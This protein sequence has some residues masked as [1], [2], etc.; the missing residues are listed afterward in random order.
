MSTS[1]EERERKMKE[2]RDKFESLQ[3]L[4]DPDASEELIHKH[5]GGGGVKTNTENDG[6]I[7]SSNKDFQMSSTSAKKGSKWNLLKKVVVSESAVSTS[8]SSVVS[9][10]HSWKNLQKNL[11]L[12]R[13]SRNSEFLG[14]ETSET[15]SALLKTPTMKA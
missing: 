2:M 1:T 14:R 3:L 4:V 12:E 5:L 15:V 11:S 6:P 10:P 13:K 8:D 9:V 7:S